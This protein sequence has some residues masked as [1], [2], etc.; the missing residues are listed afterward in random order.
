MT[1][2]M[3]FGKYKGYPLE[4][5]PNQYFKALFESSFNVSLIKYPTLY[6]KTHKELAKIKPDFESRL[7]L[8]CN[9]RKKTY[10]VG[11]LTRRKDYKGDYENIVKIIC[12]K[13]RKDQF[14]RTNNDSFY[15][16]G[17]V[18]GKMC[19]T[20]GCGED[21]TVVI[22]PS[23]DTVV[24]RNKKYQRALNKAL[25]AE[26]D[27]KI[28]DLP[29][30]SNELKK[31]LSSLFVEGMSLENYGS[32]HIDHIKPISSFLFLDEEDF[33][34]CWSL[35]NFQPLWAYDNIVKG[36]FNRKKERNKYKMRNKN[37]YNN[38]M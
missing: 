13:C 8:Q 38:S 21:M 9:C 37:E 3:E 18:F 32:W 29:Y 36:G 11:Y 22:V 26:A 35:D 15:E 14:R 30:T 33:T 1:Y 31:H 5:I 25:R 6:C 12:A 28:A 4:L 23:I 20:N 34:K 2:L 17:A 24:K 16:V 19:N 27:T 7:N 10:S